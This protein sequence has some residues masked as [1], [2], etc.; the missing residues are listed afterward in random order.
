VLY[1]NHYNQK[2]LLSLVIKEWTVAPGTAA[3]LQISEK[4]EYLYDS[5]DSLT[6]IRTF[7]K[8]QDGDYVFSGQESFSDSLYTKYEIDVYSGDTTYF[9]KITK[10][11][12]GNILTDGFK[13]KVPNVL[14]KPTFEQRTVKYSYDKE[15]KE[16]ANTVF[17]MT[18]N[19]SKKIVFQYTTNGDTLIKSVFDEEKNLLIL[20]KIITSQNMDEEFFYDKNEVLMDYS[21]TQ[22]E[23]GKV[24]L[25][26][27]SSPESIDSIYFKNEKEIRRVSISK[28]NDRFIVTKTQ[29]D[30]K[31]NI[32][33]EETYAYEKRK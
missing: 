25:Q 26:T 30:E 19:S 31:G 24:V 5:N 32:I 8:N 7:E 16:S 20:T 33:K 12:V 6:G 3:S 2:G 22:K 27:S 15:G 21:I 10:N 17:N 4:L 23:N 29:Y 28:Q 14:N 9:R 1:E 11:K 13:R 18:D